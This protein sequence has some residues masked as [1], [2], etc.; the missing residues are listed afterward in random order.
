[1]AEKRIDSVRQEME[2]SFKSKEERYDYNNVQCA[3]VVIQ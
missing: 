1:M 3:C 2:E